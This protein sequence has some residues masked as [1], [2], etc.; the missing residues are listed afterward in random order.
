[1]TTAVAGPDAGVKQ[2][3]R[4]RVGRVSLLG[5]LTVGL[6]VLLF[7]LEREILALTARGGWSFLIPVGIA[8]LFSV[9]HGKFTGEFWDV[10]GIKAKK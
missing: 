4:A 6:Y 1:M 9:V 7:S 3:R 2:N 10:L 8:F 5:L